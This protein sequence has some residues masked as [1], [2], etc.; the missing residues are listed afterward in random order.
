MKLKDEA[1]RLKIKKVSLE[2]VHKKGLSGLKISEVAKRAGISPSNLYIY[3]KNKEDLLHE[4][5]IEIVEGFRT[6]LEK[7]INIDVPYKIQI[8]TLFKASLRHKVKKTKEVSFMKQFIQS[9]F[10][11]K[12]Y[13]NKIENIMHN[14]FDIVKQGQKKMI[15]KDNIDPDL[16]LAVIE[17]TSDKLIEFNNGGKINLTEEAIEQT[18]LLVWDAIKQ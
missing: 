16:L 14:V 7:E 3:F 5:F 8:I 1:K 4:I 9:P 10:F 18:S 12:R 13:H 15:L 17:G 6:I 2:I 11:N